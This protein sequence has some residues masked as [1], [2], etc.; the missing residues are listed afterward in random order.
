[1][2]LL[3][4]FCFDRENCSFSRRKTHPSAPVSGLPDGG[5]DALK[6][7]RYHV[8]GPQQWPA[9][10]LLGL[11]ALREGLLAFSPF[12]T[13]T[14]GFRRLR[15]TQDVVLAG[16]ESTPTKTQNQGFFF[17]RAINR[18]R[19]GIRVPRELCVEVLPGLTEPRENAFSMPETAPAKNCLDS[20]FPYPY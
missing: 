2:S 12:E 17:L 14:S 15:P 18:L 19:R 8:S 11:C 16:C 3:F 5:A 1:V 9:G 10:P 13:R 6:F 4:H 20:G 7:C